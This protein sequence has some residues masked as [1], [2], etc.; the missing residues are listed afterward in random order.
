MLRISEERLFERFRRQR[1]ASSLAR[2]FDRTAPALLRLAWHLSRDRHV[3]ED[4][5][6][7]TFLSAIENADRW[8]RQRRLF[9]WLVGI[10]TNRARLHQRAQRRAP[11]VERLTGHP[12]EQPPDAAAARE[13]E[14][15]VEQAITELGDTY[16]P[17]LH[18]HLF[19][20]LNAKQIAAAL[21]RPPGSVRTQLVRGLER[22][23]RTLPVGLGVAMTVT[24]ARVATAALR[25]R[26]L[27]T[28]VPH[29]PPTVGVAGAAS[30]AIGGPL[31]KKLL[32]LVPIA[33]IGA[34]VY[35]RTPA[36]PNGL[37]PD[38]TGPAA[39][40]AASRTPID[41]EHTAPGTDQPN[42]V[43]RAAPQQARVADPTTGR[44]HIR[45]RFPDASLSA[46]GVWV[47]MR[48][49]PW[50][51]GGRRFGARIDSSGAVRFE[52]VPAGSWLVEAETGGLG[53]KA[54]LRVDAGGE[55]DLRMTFERAIPIRVRVVDDAHRPVPDAEI[56]ICM[57]YSG[58]VWPMEV[59]T[60][61][62]GRADATGRATVAAG[63][64]SRVG[65][66]KPG[67]AA[68]TAVR[69]DASSGEEVVLMLT[70]GPGTLRGVAVDED[71]RPIRDAA[72][73]VV[74]RPS[75]ERGIPRASD[76][77]GAEPPAN[78]YTAA[79][80]DGTF[81]IEGLR[82][83]RYQVFGI[84]RGVLDA[85]LDV[86]VRAYE[87]T[88]LRL[89][90]RRTV[91]V[92]VRTTRTDGTP[93]AG[94][95]VYGRDQSGKIVGGGSITDRDGIL[96]F[97]TP[98][99]GYH[100][101]VK[102]E[103]TLLAER[104][105]EAPLTGPVD[106]GIVIDEH[107]MVRGKLVDEQGAPIPGWRVAAVADTASESDLMR[108]LA[109]AFDAA[110]KADGT[111]EIWGNL[112]EPLQVAARETGVDPRSL[113]V[114]RG[115]PVGTRDLAVVVPTGKLPRSVLTGRVVDAQGRLLLNA[116][117]RTFQSRDESNGCTA[118]L[119]RVTGLRHGKR[120]FHIAAPGF[121]S[122]RLQVDIR[123]LHTDVGDIVLQRAVELRVRPVFPSAGEWLGPLPRASLRAATGNSLWPQPVPR[124]R[125]GVLVFL[126]LPP[127]DY[128]LHPHH[129][130]QIASDP[131]AFTLVADTPKALDWPVRVGRKRLLLF[132]PAVDRRAGPDAMLHVRVVT[133]RDE[134]ALDTK[135]KSW[136]GRW[137]LRHTFV[138][139]SYRVTSESG[140]GHAFRGAFAVR[141]DQG[142]GENES[143]IE[144]PPQR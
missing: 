80:E 47:S 97:A 46:H 127:G 131:V 143:R 51:W 68:S 84:A 19:H 53:T 142:T 133:E 61:M 18:L 138:P 31:M 54:N 9:P 102:R 63:R 93:I 136:N 99:S 137:V 76:G 85:V 13:L 27:S 89:E 116:T 90:M 16:R 10:L 115:I 21:G 60:R 11:D 94:L 120:S 56:W 37:L 107:R 26:V 2:V 62:A 132:T 110:T 67:F 98:R 126:D 101:E 50:A 58:R 81:A 5:V 17:V 139:G 91:R 36:L 34:L 1:D 22:L 12:A 66:C 79:A 135:V 128:V 20:G 96:T 83:G 42:R 59:T 112:R 117:A 111:F 35:W 15:A 41:P 141:L 45:V 57:Q 108:A 29:L 100:I 118:G 43:E 87:A 6:Q 14:A 74:S 130:E 33:L 121:G 44:V 144:V 78:V 4:L 23:R 109:F 71:G 69:A 39:E 103:Q 113:V 72:V 104:R 55:H 123:S 125:D 48:P 49:D 106:V 82:P 40:I 92:K 122:R 7:Q 140:A 124:V 38:A 134:V 75:G 30:L 24:T 77:R 114:E 65:A 119:V 88:P 129:G 86:E 8:D 64:D 52:G 25:H 95:L 28:C 73:F 70:R 32:I 105:S 3:A